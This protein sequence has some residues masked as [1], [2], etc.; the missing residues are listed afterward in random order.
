MSTGRLVAAV[1]SCAL[2]GATFAPLPVSAQPYWYAGGSVG[3]S[4]IDATSAEIEQGFL[5]DD[6][7][8]VSG[9][10]LDDTD[11]GW[12]AYLGYR[13]NRFLAAE[14]GYADLGKAS[15]AT[16]IVSAPAPFSALTPFPIHAT[17]TA[18]GAFLSG[19]VHLPLTECFSLFAKA[20]AYR[21]EAKFT[22]RIPPTGITRLSRTERKTD[23]NY[24]AGLQ[25]QF[26][27]RVGGRLEWERFK[28]VG[29]G[30]GARDGQDI[31]FISAGLFF[32]F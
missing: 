3:Q 13:F 1:L 4:A 29:R 15:F 30:I 12:K 10:T 26:T 20:G 22:E 8:V 16:T 2:L 7:F 5:A 17:A 32:R 31:E 11:T 6:A 24:G 9:T 28:D 14:G 18:R 19:L 21:W 25:W 27:S 23:L